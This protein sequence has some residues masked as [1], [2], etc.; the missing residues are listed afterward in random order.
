MTKLHAG[1]NIHQPPIADEVDFDDTVCAF[2][3]D[4][5]QGAIDALCQRVATSA[6]P[7][8][9]WG[10]SGN[11]V[12]AWLLND[13]VPSNKAGRPIF[14]NSAEIGNIFV[15]NEN[16]NTFDVAIYEHVGVG[17]EILLVTVNI[18]A[19]RSA[20]FTVSVPITT[21]KELGV[22]IVGSAKNPVV[23]LIIKGT[24]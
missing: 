17:T 21:G 22:K 3:E 19:A 10:A 12:N 16:I 1:L 11:V 15:A 14:L 5:V 24:L 6:S 7:G 13:T 23:S 20:G 4:E 8:F 2:G 18:V 9:T